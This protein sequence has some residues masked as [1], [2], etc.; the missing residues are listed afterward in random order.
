MLVPMLAAILLRAGVSMAWQDFSF[1]ERMRLIDISWERAGASEREAACGFLNSAL[2]ARIAKNYESSSLEL[3][4]ALAA[5]SKRTVR[6]EDAID[7]AFA[8]PVVEPGKEAELQVHWAYVPAGAKAITISAGDHDVLCQPGRPVSISVR[9]ADVLPEVENHPESV[10]PIPVQVGSVTKFATISISSR[11]RARAEGFLSSS[12]P[13]VRGLAEGAQRI[14]DGK[15]V[16]QS[17]VDSLSLAES[18]QAGKKRL[19]D[20]LTFP[21][22]VSEGAL[23]R[24]SLPKVLPKSRRVDVLVCVAASGFSFSDYADAYGRGAIAQQAAQRGW[25][26]IAIE[27]GAPHSV[28]KALRWLEDTC[29]IKPGRL[30]LMGHGAGGDALVSDAEALTGVAASAILGPNLS[31]LPASLLAHP[32]FIAAGKNDPFSEQPMAKLTELLKGRKD[33]ELFRPER[34][35]HLMV[36]ATAGE[37][38]FKFFDQLGR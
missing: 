34:C 1:S 31:Q 2:R 21:S 27:P 10:A 23:F 29:G 13:A 3:D 12:N 22:V 28:S 4:H 15:M 35:E 37:Q 33:V 18:L 8:S 20:V 16:R 30:F 17:P 7:V 32:V 5:L 6:L 9:P 11:T 14:L 36:V 19:A 25:A 38:M 24:V 26:M